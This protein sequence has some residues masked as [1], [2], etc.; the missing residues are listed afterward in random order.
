M[1]ELLAEVAN[2]D[3]G[4]LVMLADLAEHLRKGLGESQERWVGAR[5]MVEFI[6]E[7]FVDHFG[8]DLLFHKRQPPKPETVMSFAYVM[9][10]INAVTEDGRR[11]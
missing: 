8:H 6:G 3:P 5:V 10:V 9:A 1:G 2:H 11:S 7:A 4:L